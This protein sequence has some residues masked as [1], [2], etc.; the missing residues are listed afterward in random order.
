MTWTTRAFQPYIAWATPLWIKTTHT[1]LDPHEFLFIFMDDCVLFI[2]VFFYHRLSYEIQICHSLTFCK[3]VEK[4]YSC[5]TGIAHYAFGKWSPEIELGF[6]TG[7]LM[8]VCRCTLC[9]EYK[10]YIEN[11]INF[12]RSC[13]IA[14]VSAGIDYHKLCLLYQN[15]ACPQILISDGD[16]LV[17]KSGVDCGRK[18]WCTCGHLGEVR[19]RWWEGS[20]WQ[21]G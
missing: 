15:I 21:A 4:K 11:G 5:P 9:T 10:V 19:H 16:F 17:L 12:W 8:S 18:M 1:T 13:A 3:R 14:V 7:T 2:F 6:P 20:L